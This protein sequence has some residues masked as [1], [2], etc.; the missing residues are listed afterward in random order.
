[1]VFH[2]LVAQVRSKLYCSCVQ[3]VYVRHAPTGW[4]PIAAALVWL[5]RMMQF[6]DNDVNVITT[7]VYRIT[8]A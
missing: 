4:V 8:I 2:D 1:M 6:I 7:A 3:I 5:A